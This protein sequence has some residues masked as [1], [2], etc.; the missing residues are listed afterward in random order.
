MDINNAIMLQAHGLPIEPDGIKVIRTEYIL[1][2]KHNFV[3]MGFDKEENARAYLDK[4][5]GRYL[6]LVKRV[7]LEEVLI[8][9]E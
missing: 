7:T 3:V 2:S 8:D 4:N 6:I 9:G 1:K 5:P